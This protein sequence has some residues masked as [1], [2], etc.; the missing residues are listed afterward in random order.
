M[1]W[2]WSVS[3]WTQTQRT[4]WVEP[5]YEP[6]TVLLYSHNLGKPVAIELKVSYWIVKKKKTPQTPETYFFFSFM[7]IPL[8][9]PKC[10][11]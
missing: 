7:N 8:N 11:D 6:N 10:K 5:K 2:A 3:P 1:S 9:L 4:P